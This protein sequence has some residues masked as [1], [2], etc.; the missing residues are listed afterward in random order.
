MKNTWKFIHQKVDLYLN[1][2]TQ[3][4]S[5]FTPQEWITHDYKMSIVNFP[6]ILEGILTTNFQLCWI[7][8]TSSIINPATKKKLAQKVVYVCNVCFCNWTIKA[9]RRISCLKIG[10]T[11]YIV[12][13]SSWKLIMPH[14]FTIWLGDNIYCWPSK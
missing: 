14:H 6:K 2:F 12:A 13:Q 11:E 4:E 9:N 7:P 10:T 5:P 1:C 3:V 8:L